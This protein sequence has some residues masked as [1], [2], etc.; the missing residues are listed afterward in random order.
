MTKVVKRLLRAALQRVHEAI[1][2]TAVAAA[3]QMLVG[4][5]H[6]VNTGHKYRRG[7]KTEDPTAPPH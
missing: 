3:D 6:W 4:F 2:I 1:D 5:C 7:Q